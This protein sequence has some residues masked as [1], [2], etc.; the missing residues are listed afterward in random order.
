MYS[1]AYI[2]RFASIMVI[3]VAAILTSVALVLKPYQEYNRKVEKITDI[4]SAAGIQAD[5]QNAL[6]EY[7]KSMK[8]ELA[9]GLDGQIMGVYRDGKMLEGDVR[10]FE[11]DVKA[12]LKQIADKSGDPLLPLFHLVKSDGSEV[13]VVPV[14]GKG[15]WGPI[16]GNIALSPDFNTIIGASFDHKSETPGLGA[17]INTDEFE[18]QFIGKKIFNEAGEFISVEVVKGG[19]ANSDIPPEFGVDAISGGTITSKALESMVKT[20]LSNYKNYIETTQK[21]EAL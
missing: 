7:N 5:A 6:E 15:L 18:S 17:E 12:V 13:F 20:C 2:F 4:L 9:I 11:I 10:A 21:L 8:E 1:N 3:L 16:W 19:V 14:R